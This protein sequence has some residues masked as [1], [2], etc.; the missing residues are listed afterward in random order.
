[1]TGSHGMQH[2]AQ[3][4]AML[5]K[6]IV[7]APIGQASRA[8]QIIERLSNAIV[9]GL[10]QDEEQLPNEAELS[11][12]LGV[13]PMTV[14][15][16]L[17]TLRVRGLIDTRR[18][19]HGGS[20]VSRRSLQ[21][22]LSHHPLRLLASDYLA[23]LGEYHLAVAGHSAKLATQR[24]TPAELARFATLVE[25]FAQARAQADMRCL[26]A[27]AGQAQSAR[28]ANQMLEVQAE[29][30]PLV[31]LLYDRPDTHAESV[32]T[33]RSVCSAMASGDDRLVRELMQHGIATLTDGLLA[34]KLQLDA[35]ASSSSTPPPAS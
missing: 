35:A 32:R 34:C 12:L 2:D 20:F 21:T 10:L 17:N 23:D 33:Y 29:W 9:S 27:L 15:E 25:D 28:L 7:Y 30:A 1:M 31:A 8:E 13:S 22:L 3:A 11:R 6:A 26:L 19:R 5:T 18:G 24:A 16:A 4:T 14:R